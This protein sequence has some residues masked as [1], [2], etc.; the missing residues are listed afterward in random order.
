MPVYEPSSLVQVGEGGKI[1]TLPRET[2]TVSS[3]FP[4]A[5]LIS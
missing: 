1:V 3:D 2:A 5:N 4:G